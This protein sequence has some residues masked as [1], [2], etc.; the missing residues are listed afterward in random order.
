MSAT[1]Q[2]ISSFRITLPFIRDLRT[3]LGSINLK[4]FVTFTITPSG[5]RITAEEGGVVQ[6]SGFYR[7]ELCDSF[8][9]GMS[10]GIISTTSPSNLSFIVNIA[11]LQ[12]CLHAMSCSDDSVGLVGDFGAPACLSFDANEARTF[13]MEIKDGQIDLKWFSL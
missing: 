13:N 10:C 1:A 4:D 3:L 9:I 6:A 7:S 12:E 11:H 8:E 2:C 5:F